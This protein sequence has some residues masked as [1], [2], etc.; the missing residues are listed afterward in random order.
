MAIMANPDADRGMKSPPVGE[1]K[2]PKCAVEC[3]AISI[4]YWPFCFVLYKQ[5]LQYSDECK[6]KNTKYPMED[7][8]FEP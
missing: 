6:I 7:E 8:L 3:N 2:P 4:L 5:A 1:T